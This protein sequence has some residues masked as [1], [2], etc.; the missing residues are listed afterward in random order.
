MALQTYRFSEIVGNIAAAVQSSASALTDFTVGSVLRAIAEATA[1]VCLW[2]QAIIL[3]VL[4]LTRAATSKG[5]DLDSWCADYGFERLEASASTG[6]VTFAR[7]TATQQALIA[8]GATVQTSDGSQN[9]TVTLDTT[10]SAYNPTLG[11]YVIPANTASVS[12]PV[13]NTVSGSSG[14]VQASTIAVITKPIPGVDTVTNTAAFTNG[15]DAESDPAFRIR[16]VAYLGSLSKAT[17]AAVAY[18]VTSARQGLDY[19]I[20]Q[21]YAYNGTYQPGYFYVV[22]DDGTGHPSDTLLANVANSI[23]AVRG[24]TINFGVFAPV[25]TTANVGMVLATAAGHTHATVVAAVTTALTDF[26][27]SLHV[28]VSLPYTQ[29]AGIAYDVPGV[30]N[31]TSITLNSGTSDLAADD[32]HKIVAGTI[33]VA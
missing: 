3:Q 30:A 17:G 14:N 26:I 31:A 25:V 29:L 24:L 16:F 15:I 21:N 4:T 33:A 22:V 8:V 20:T 32:R 9:F 27:N 7:F 18:A 19:T 23:D 12:V 13:E 6:Q 10:N 5:A 2:L 11:G 1:S 28:G